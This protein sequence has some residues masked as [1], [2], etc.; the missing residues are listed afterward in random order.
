MEMK[1]E[2]GEQ[3]FNSEIYPGCA[4][5]KI[6]LNLFVSEGGINGSKNLVPFQSN[7]KAN[8]IFVDISELKLLKK[9]V[10]AAKVSLKKESLT[11]AVKSES[12]YA[13]Q[14]FSESYLVVNDGSSEGD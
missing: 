2:E 3:N 13:Q 7:H 6:D 5:S 12:D 9:F 11:L 10:V 4:Y 1:R 8:R 14:I